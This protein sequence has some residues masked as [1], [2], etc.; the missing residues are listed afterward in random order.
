M[1]IDDNSIDIFITTK[2]LENI[3][4][5]NIKSETSPE[6]ALEYLKDNNENIDKLPD[7]IFLDINMPIIDGF[8]FLYEFE[9]L[10]ELN[11][12]LSKII[13]LSSSNDDSDVNRL[14]NN[15]YVKGFI[16]K[17]LTKKAILNITPSVLNTN[18]KIY[19]NDLGYCKNI[20]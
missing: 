4:F 20:N 15:K 2:T 16:T 10:S 18:K 9:K 5:S 1:L 13:I 19:I 3:G 6:L 7:I 11:K 14:I 12:S 8:M 17:P